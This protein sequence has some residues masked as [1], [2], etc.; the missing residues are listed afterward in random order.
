MA[1]G[2]YQIINLDNRKAY[3][4]S[5]VNLDKRWRGHKYELR[6]NEHHS[7]YLQNAWDKYGEDAFEFNVLL[8]CD[9]DMLLFYEQLCMDNLNSEY[10]MC[11]VAGSRL[12]SSTS[13]ETKRKLRNA[14]RGNKHSAGY[15]NHLG[16]THSA[17]ARRRMGIPSIGNKWGLGWTPSAD[18][19]HNFSQSHKGN[20][21]S[22]ETRQKMSESQ[23]SRK[24]LSPDE[25]LNI[26]DEYMNNKI[27]QRELGIKYGVSTSAIN[28][29]I[30]KFRALRS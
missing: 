19:L 9:Q 30:K 6:K 20:K 7:P 15:K 17:D 29:V 8:R 21:P 25:R 27:S 2:I 24:L 28:L 26:Y 1:S 18:T 13:E 10:N 4:G 12:G 22:I 3:I 14:S 16:H 23:R 5:A 11:R